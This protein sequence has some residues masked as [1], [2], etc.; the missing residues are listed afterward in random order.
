MRNERWKLGRLRYIFGLRMFAW[1]FR[2]GS[3]VK[4]LIDVGMFDSVVRVVFVFWH[5]GMEGFTLGCIFFFLVL[6]FIVLLV[7]AWSYIFFDLAFLHLYCVFG[8]VDA[9]SI[10]WEIIRG[11]V[12]GRHPLSVAYVKVMSLLRELRWIHLIVRKFHSRVMEIWKMPV[13]SAI[14]NHEAWVGL[15]VRLDILSRPDVCKVW[16]MQLVAKVNI[17][18]ESIQQRIGLSQFVIV[19]FYCIRGAFFLLCQVLMLFHLILNALRFCVVLVGIEN[20]LITRSALVQAALETEGVVGRIRDQVGRTRRP[21]WQR[22]SAWK[23]RGGK[24]MKVV[25]SVLLSNIIKHLICSPIFNVREW[26]VPIDIKQ[27]LACF[28]VWWWLAFDR[29]AFLP[30]MSVG[31]HRYDCWWIIFYFGCD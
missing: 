18:L 1:L 14:V 9:V 17:I 31:L 7:C 4:R 27:Q 6:I 3:L 2:F 22:L 10:F 8:V 20:R 26:R 30:M 24:L 29:N 28:M 25:G 21:W 19:I 23:R 16:M 15:R 13:G 5:A 11:T 12:L